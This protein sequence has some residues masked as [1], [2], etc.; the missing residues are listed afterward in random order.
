MARKWKLAAHTIAWPRGEETDVFRMLEEI[1]G[2]GYE[3]VQFMH[4]VEAFGSEAALARLEL[5]MVSIGGPEV[6][7]R[8]GV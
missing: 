6:T 1:A 2:L 5:G 3:G 7:A 4:P 8:L